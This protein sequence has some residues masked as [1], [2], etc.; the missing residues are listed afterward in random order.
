MAR[1]KYSFDEKKIQKFLDEGRG[2]G[3]GGEYKLRLIVQDVPAYSLTSKLL[4]TSC[5]G[6]PWTVSCYN[7]AVLNSSV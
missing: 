3:S 6:Y 1:K 5:T 4:Q 2:K 7:A